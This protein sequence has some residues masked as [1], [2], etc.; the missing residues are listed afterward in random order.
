MEGIN[1]YSKVSFDGTSKTMPYVK[2]PV[3]SSDKSIIWNKNTHKLDDLSYKYYGI[4]SEGWIIIQANPQFGTD[5]Y[6]FP[7]GA[8]IR[9]P[10]PYNAVEQSFKDE[11]AR[12]DNKFGI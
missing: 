11:L 5:E 4:G 7:N 1:R 9:I 10:Y 8:L 12:F 6:D 2:I 3:R